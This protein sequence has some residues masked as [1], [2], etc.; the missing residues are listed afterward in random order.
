M[1]VQIREPNWTQ[2]TEVLVQVLRIEAH[3]SPRLRSFDFAELLGMQVTCLDC[4]D[5]AQPTFINDGFEIFPVTT[6]E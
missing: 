5:A 6:Q 4:R 2:I 3:A 1:A